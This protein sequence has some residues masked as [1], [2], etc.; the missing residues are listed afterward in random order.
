M[1]HYP[2][3]TKW[4]TIRQ[5]AD[6][7]PCFTESSLRWLVFHQS[8]N[9]FDRCVRRIGKKI[10]ISLADFENWVESHGSSKTKGGL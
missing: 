4:L 9:G 5:L 3:E 6:A 2:Q 8:T 7:N 1:T 10:L